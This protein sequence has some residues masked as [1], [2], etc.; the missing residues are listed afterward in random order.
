MLQTFAGQ[1]LTHDEVK[2]LVRA[3]RHWV[4]KHGK[5]PRD[6]QAGNI[7]INPVDKSTFMLFDVE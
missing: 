7:G 5:F 2:N 3:T 1:V 6:F 4:K